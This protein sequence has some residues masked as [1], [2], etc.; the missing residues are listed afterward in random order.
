MRCWWSWP[1]SGEAEAAGA[2]RILPPAPPPMS[3]PLILLSIWAAGLASAGAWTVRRRA[4]GV[5]FTWLVAGVVAVVAA[6]MVGFGAGP[7]SWLTLG[8]SVVASATARRFP[9][10]AWTSLAVA[11]GG[12]VGVAGPAGGWPS[13]VTGAVALGA[14]TVEMLLG[15]WFLVDP[16][17]PRTVLRSLAVAG[18]VGAAA[19]G[20]VQ[21]AGLV[22]AGL[23][24]PF[25]VFPLTFVVLSATTVLLM[26]GVF[27]S[28]REPGYSGVMAA[29]G[30]SY[31]AVLTALGAVAVPRWLQLGA[32]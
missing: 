18:A 8:A 17:L 3:L 15:H 19:D 32:A 31:L 22:S 4:A 26:V 28:L 7:W 10:V 9:T 27:F 1:P 13:A 14:I 6:G 16:T 30:L 29:T 25:G 20:A 12:A 11:A 2:G 5:G 21:V 24:D 23:W